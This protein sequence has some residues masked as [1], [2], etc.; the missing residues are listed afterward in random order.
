MPLWVGAIVFVKEFIYVQYR[1]DVEYLENLVSRF[2]FHK[3]PVIF[4]Y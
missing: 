4:I 1:F 2:Y 3:E